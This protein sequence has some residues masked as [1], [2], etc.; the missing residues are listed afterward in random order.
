MDEYRIDATKLMYHPERVSQWKQSQSWEKAKT[1]YPIYVEIAPVGACNHRCTFCSV[2]Y[3]GYKSV[4]QDKGVLKARLSEMANLGIKAV[5]FAGEGEPLLY[6]SID[7]IVSHSVVEG[8]DVSFT[9]NGVL[10]NKLKTLNLCSWVKVSVNAGT[11]ETYAKIHQTDEKDWSRVWKNLEDGAKRKGNCTLGVQSV[12]LPENREEVISLARKCRDTGVDYL[13]IK[14]YTQSRS[15][16]SRTYEGLA[17]DGTTQGFRG[18]TNILDHEL[19]KLET[20]TF[21]VIAR[22]ESMGRA[23]KEI[24]YKKCHATPMLWAYIMADGEVYSCGAYLL[25]DKFRL[26][27]INTQ[28][29]KEIWEGRKANWDFVH[30][31]LDIT[32]CRKNCRMNAANL[33]LED[34]KTVKH[35]NFI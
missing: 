6:K 31:G 30:E 25:D 33:Y 10:L 16:E 28:T 4:Q 20:D 5:M 18:Y 24:P 35:I 13:V 1:F 11:P 32:E 15:G 17:Y 7:D 27:N 22:V 29:F 3:I 23:N 26:G 34:F 19:K 9:T 12:L 2:D 8:L 21:K 14:P